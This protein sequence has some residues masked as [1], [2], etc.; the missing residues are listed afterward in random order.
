MRLWCRYLSWLQRCAGKL[1]A[2]GCLWL[3]P[4]LLGWFGWQLWQGV[5]GI[6]LLPAMLAV[7]WCLLGLLMHQLFAAPLPVKPAGSVWRRFGWY[8]RL[9]LYQLAALLFLLLTLVCL[10]WSAK[11]LSVILRA[12]L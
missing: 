8:I 5:T 7:L 10:F 6:G 11:L 3:L 12:G 4:M 1:P 2:Q 9:G